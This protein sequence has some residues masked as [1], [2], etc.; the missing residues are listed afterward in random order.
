MQ[1]MFGKHV[2]KSTVS[3]MK[4]VK[5]KNRNR[6]ADETLD[7]SRWLANTGIGLLLI[8]DDDV[9]E[10]STGADPA[11]KFRG[12]GRF[13]KHLVVKS[14]YDFPTVREM[15]HTSQQCCDQ[16]MDDKLALYR[17][18]LFP[19]CTKSG[20]IKLLSHVLGGRSPPSGS[21]PASTTGIL[22]I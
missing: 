21:A 14:Q 22:L 7:D 18:C 4:Q 5:S 8:K 6:M 19:N 17:E 3:K 12:E 15:K 16:T 20:W 11:S 13:Q 1:W 9:I 2:C 10:A